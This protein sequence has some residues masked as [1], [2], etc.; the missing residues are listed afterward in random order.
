MDNT[1]RSALGQP[2]LD[3]SSISSGPN[4]VYLTNGTAIIYSSD[5][6]KVGA[7]PVSSPE[8][9]DREFVISTTRLS[10]E[11]LPGQYGRNWTASAYSSA[12]TTSAQNASPLLVTS[13]S[14]KNG[15][16]YL[17][18]DGSLY[19]VP[20]SVPLGVISEAYDCMKRTAGSCISASR[21]ILSDSLKAQMQDEFDSNT[22]SPFTLA[23]TERFV[24][25]GDS[26]IGSSPD[27]QVTY[28][29][30]ITASG[31]L[32]L[33]D[34][35][36]NKR[37]GDSSPLADGAT[38]NAPV[39]NFAAPIH[40]LSS[41]SLSDPLRSPVVVAQ[42]YGITNSEGSL[43]AWTF[44]Q[45]PEGVSL[46]SFLPSVTN[47]T[48]RHMADAYGQLS[49]I[50][51]EDGTAFTLDY[52]GANPFLETALTSFIQASSVG[53]ASYITQLIGTSTPYDFRFIT[54]DGKLWQYS[55]NFVSRSSL[56]VMHGY[57]DPNK[58]GPWQETLF[59][60]VVP[61]GW[62]FSE[63]RSAANYFTAIAVLLC[64][65]LI[66][67]RSIRFPR[68]HLPIPTTS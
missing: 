26:G 23:D 9:A 43:Y 67:S 60:D 3:V 64:L 29:Y 47:F 40:R 21:M 50:I 22:R 33:I 65:P 58:Q 8:D 68:H 41:E 6:Y 12:D 49:L 53:N 51:L 27:F 35:G 59:E 36:E 31:H 20:H 4:M 46:S 37:A 63:I 38:Y 19:W 5:A 48:V 45:L 14:S 61:T 11:G 10:I 52:Q 44:G 17:F 30:A 42:S 57:F 62:I 54:N 7:F 56:P 24:K 13:A 18:D 34:A 25:L 16:A 1:T 28:L 32:Y 15:R 39:L 2:S 66:L 55:T